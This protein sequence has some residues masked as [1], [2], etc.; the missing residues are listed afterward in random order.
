[1]KNAMQCAGLGV[2]TLLTGKK[3]IAQLHTQVVGQLG[4]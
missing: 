2:L 3:P 4:E 1:M